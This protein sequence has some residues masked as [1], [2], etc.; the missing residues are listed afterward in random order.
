VKLK[1]NGE[2]ER[3]KA[4]LV[5]KGYTQCEGLDYYDTFSSVAKLTTVWCLLALAIVKN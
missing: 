2:I 4:G 1:A 5:A 3:Y